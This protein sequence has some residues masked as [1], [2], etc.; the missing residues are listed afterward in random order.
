MCGIAGILNL[1]D[2]DRVERT[3]LTHM[4]GMIP[5]RGPDETGLFLDDRVGL[6]QA[7]LSI[8]DL[9]GGTQPIHNEDKTL[10]IVFNGEIFNYVELREQLMAK[11][12]SFYTTSDTEVIIHLFEEKGPDCLSD[13]NGQFAFAIWDTRACQLFVARDRLGIRPLHYTVCNGRFLFGS[14]IKSLFALKEVQRRIDPIAL[15]QVFTFWT[16]LSPRTIFQDVYELPPGHF[17]ICRNGTHHCQA[18]WDVPMTPPDQYETGSADELAE[19]VYD[20]LLDAVR[21]RLRADVPVGSYLSGGLD[22][23]AITSMIVNNFNNR[24]RTF[25]IRFE[26][27]RFD[28]GDF[29]N[30][31]VNF[32]QC[33]HSE[34]VATNAQIGTWFERVLW[35]TEKP[36]LRTSP[37]PLFLLSQMVR[38]NGFKVVLSGEGADEVFGGYNIFRETKIRRFWARQPGSERRADLIGQLYP[39]VFDNPR[40]KRAVQGFFAKQLT[41]VDNP[42]YSHLLRWG[43]T[44]RIK[45][46]FSEDLCAGLGD[47]SGLDQLRNS[48]PNDFDRADGLTK[49]QYLEMRVFMSNY[50]LSSQGDRMAM[51]NSV[52]TRVPFLDYRLV[53]LAAR[54][55]PRMKISGLTEK[56][57]LRRAVQD[58][59]PDT[60]GTRAKHPYRAPIKQGLLQ[61]DNPQLKSLVSGQAIEEAG[62]FNAN[63]VDR[64]VQRLEKTAEPSEVD[65]MALAG[66]LS[67]Q[68]IYHQFIR[69]LPK[70]RMIT[71]K[72][73]VDQRT[74][75]TQ[76]VS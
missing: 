46:F 48:L 47:Y 28:E 15:D 56:S 76:T 51:A 60:I 59:L 14:E 58:I 24:V 9:A 12:H 38:E 20:L 4:I 25:G 6:A 69:A 29:Q 71:P 68:S 41:E 62:L 40:L 16:T 21:L 33:R 32:L 27:D 19:Q 75:I 13:L 61:N 55:E 11:G 66:I 53:E 45:M 18:Y 3:D 30:Q 49:A 72:L 52:E 1:S 7:R 23:S 57:I 54:I 17:M 36:M 5:H 10:W 67:T 64:L 37:I 35:H 74:G 26:E 73:V 31:M 43:N 39:Y 65:N 8:I 42:F 2:A 22:S 34:I 50:L 63:K 70:P 44:S